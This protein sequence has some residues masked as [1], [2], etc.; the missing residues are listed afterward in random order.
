MECGGLDAADELV[1]DRVAAA[2]VGEQLPDH[3]TEGDEQTDGA[4]GL[5]ETGRE[6]VDGGLAWHLGDGGERSGEQGTRRQ[7]DGLRLARA[8]LR[9]CFNRLP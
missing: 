9:V 5:A 4:G 6:A 8:Q 1:D 2:G 3:R 7:R